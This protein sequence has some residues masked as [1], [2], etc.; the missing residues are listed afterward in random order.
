MKEHEDI[1]SGSSKY[2]LDGA[3]TFTLMKHKYKGHTRE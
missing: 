1:R 3:N 2:A